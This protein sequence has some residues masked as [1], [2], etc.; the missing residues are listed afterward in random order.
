MVGSTHDDIIRRDAG[1]TGVG[2]LLSIDERA[3]PS[4]PGSV[5]STF[6]S[7]WNRLFHP[8]LLQDL[9]NPSLSVRT[10]CLLVEEVADML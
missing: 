6:L 9:G 4:S 10:H 8:T 5:S 2:S 3:K 7:I 1:S